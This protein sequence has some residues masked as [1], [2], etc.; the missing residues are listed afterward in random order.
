MSED[1][2]TGDIEIAAE[3]AVSELE[4]LFPPRPGG[5]VDTWRKQEAARKAA[6]EEQRNSSEPVQERAYRALKVTPESPEVLSAQ[7]VNIP[8]GGYAMILPLSPMRYEAV[9]SVPGYQSSIAVSD[10]GSVAD[11]GQYDTWIYTADVP[12]GTYNVTA[13]AYLSGTPA[14]GD[15]NNMEVIW[16]TSQSIPVPNPAT[17]DTPVTVSG[18]VTITSAGGFGVQSIN[19]ASG[20]GVTYNASIQVS[21][22]AGTVTPI[23]LAKDSGSAIG[24]NGFQLLYG[25]ALTLHNRGQL[26]AFNSSASLIQVSV[27]ASLYAPREGQ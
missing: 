18:V 7:T 15:G 12:A 20:S 27:M 23:L 25:Q 19:A 4:K 22:V 14:A 24:G 8:A 9:I 6:G 10:M 16:G 11:P 5:A 2:I 13:T 17:A 21:P 3:A 26:Y 1:S